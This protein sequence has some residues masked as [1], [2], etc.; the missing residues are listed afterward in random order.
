MIQT[1]KIQNYNS[2]IVLIKQTLNKTKYKTEQFRY[3]KIKH[4]KTIQRLSMQI[5]K[6]K[7]VQ[8][9]TRLSL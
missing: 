1:Q 3:A 4:T 2:N 5:Y 6:C 9:K 7:T 8:F